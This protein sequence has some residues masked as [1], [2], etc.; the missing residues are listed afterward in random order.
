[1]VEIFASL[2]EYSGR[3]AVQVASMDITERKATEDAIRKSEDHLIRIINNTSDLIFV[4]DRRHRIILVNDAACGFFRIPRE[5]LMGKTP[6]IYGD[7]RLA[8]S[9]WEEEEGVFN[10]GKECITEAQFYDS[11]GDLHTMVTKKTLLTDHEGNKQIVAISRDIT[12]YKNLQNQFLQAQ[13][14]EA[15]GA[16]AGGLAHDLNNMCNVITGYAELVMEDIAPD[17]P[18]RPDLEQIIK[19]GKKAASLVSQLLAF[20]RKQIFEPEVLSLNE[21]IEEMKPMLAR[22]LGASI[23]LATRPHPDLGLVSADQAQIQQVIMNLAVNARDAMPK[24]GKLTI[25]TANVDFNDTDI[26][27]DPSAGAGPYI[28]LAVSDDGIGMDEATQAHLFEPFFTTKEPG[29]GTGLGLSTVYGIVKQSNGFIR[30]YSRP[31][32]GATFRIYLPRADGEKSAH[33]AVPAERSEQS[34]S[35]TILLVEDEQAIRSLVAR[36]LRQNGYTVIE[37]CDGT[38][39]IRLSRECAQEIH[40]VVTDV[41]MPGMGGRE[42]VGELGKSRPGIKSLYMSGYPN[43]TIFHHNIPDEGDEGIEFLQKPFTTASL[44]RR[45]RDVLDGTVSRY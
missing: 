45:I 4:M 3:P 26:E 6:H 2:M 33:H 42:V 35:E 12:E 36:V 7:R 10:T 29:K 34:G 13:K 5:E 43:E 23:D 14:M 11:Q 40:M 39:A 19:A 16:L 18:V 31:G 38:D 1:W 24:G 37:A 30:V 20:S 28:M 44:A 25:E 21:L 8:T 9:L 22:L 27:K 17:Y 32:K 41:V 15:I